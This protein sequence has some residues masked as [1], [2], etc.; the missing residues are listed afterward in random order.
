[1]GAALQCATRAPTCAASSGDVCPFRMQSTCPGLKST[2][3]G[4]SHTK[5]CNERKGGKRLQP[6]ASS[7]I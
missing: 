6:A 1:M 7:S 3:R 2:V 4:D 5:K